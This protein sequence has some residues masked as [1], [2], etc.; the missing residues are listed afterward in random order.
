[1]RTSC[2]LQQRGARHVTRY[3][4]LKHRATAGSNCD[5]CDGIEVECSLA[6]SSA[7]YRC[8]QEIGI[9]NTNTSCV[10]QHQQ[11]LSK[12][13]KRCKATAAATAAGTAFFSTASM[14][15]PK[16]TSLR[17]KPLFPRQ[18]PPNMRRLDLRSREHESSN[19][20]NRSAPD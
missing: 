4:H 18:R 13:A 6:T 19:A 17:S 5:A 12:K 15:R 9:T 7:L 3:L 1:M 14:P 20:L 16:I 2:S 11:K 8:Y 10:L